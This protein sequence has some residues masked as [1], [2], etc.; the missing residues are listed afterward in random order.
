MGESRDETQAELTD[1]TLLKKLSDPP[2]TKPGKTER[3]RCGP[4]VLKV[5]HAKAPRV[6]SLRINPLSMEMS[7]QAMP[8]FSLAHLTDT[9]TQLPTQRPMVSQT[10]SKLNLQE[11]LPTPIHMP[12]IPPLPS[13]LSP[14]PSPLSSLA[15][16]P[17]SLETRNDTNISNLETELLN[18]LNIEDIAKLLPVLAALTD[19][20]P[21]TVS[22]SPAIEDISLWSPDMVKLFT[23]ALISGQTTA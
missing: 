2:A 14:L 13:S 9:A 16:S 8:V 10:T 4:K 6:Q 23:D 7:S 1:K 5:K 17:L 3:K 21:E 19:T 22:Q 15:P 12:Q 18:L 20:R 11:Q